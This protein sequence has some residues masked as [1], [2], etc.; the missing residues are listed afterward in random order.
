MHE[1]K[2]IWQ[3]AY[4]DRELTTAEREAI[5]AAGAKRVDRVLGAAA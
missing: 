1:V 5:A 2:P 4:E 3:A